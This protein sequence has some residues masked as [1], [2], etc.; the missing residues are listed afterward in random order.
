MGWP[1]IE[2]QWLGQQAAL[3]WEASGLKGLQLAASTCSVMLGG[4]GAFRK[5]NT[6]AQAAAGGQ[7]LGCCDLLSCSPCKWCIQLH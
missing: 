2:L 3:A 4:W 7:E 6:P 5:Q 1:E